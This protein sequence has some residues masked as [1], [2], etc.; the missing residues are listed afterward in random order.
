M[1]AP[2]DRSAVFAG[3]M[4]GNLLL[5]GLVEVLTIPIFSIL[6]R[7]SVL[8]CLPRLALVAFLGTLG[9][10][11][12]GTLLSALASGTRLR[13]VL[14]P[15]LLYPVWVPV[16]IAATQLTGQA[17]GGR[18]AAEGERWLALIAAYDIVFVTA[19]LLLF[20]RLLEE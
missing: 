6:M 19:G 10:S 2:V 1:L 15:L 11:A 9:F 17:L 13:E 7:V 12:V 14:L 20:D 4:L 16:L 18:P 3:K 5:I 8:S